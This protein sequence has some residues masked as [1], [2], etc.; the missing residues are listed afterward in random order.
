MQFATY[1]KKQGI[2]NNPLLHFKGNRFNVI[3][4]NG[5]SYSMKEKITSDLTEYGLWIT[6]HQVHSHLSAM[7]S[8]TRKRIAL[9][10]QL[11]FRKTVLQQTT[12]DSLYKFSSKNKGHYSS[13]LLCQ[14]LL[15]LITDADHT[16]GTVSSSTDAD[17]SGK[18]IMHNFED[19]DGA[20]KPYKGKVIA[21]VPG[22][23]EWYN[24]VYNEEPVV[25][26]MFK[27]NDDFEN[28]DLKI[29]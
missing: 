18:C 11:R 14:N 8:E 20:I 24:V 26:Y 16:S 1:L 13:Q 19:S 7:K 9:K 22:F 6:T 15:K 2:A 28:G 3:F 4:S 29:E 5:G 25:V 10:A 12:T 27:L 21:Q 23:L 17:L